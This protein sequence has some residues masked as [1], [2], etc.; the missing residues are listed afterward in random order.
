M[1]QSGL[2]FQNGNW[3]CTFEKLI[4]HHASHNYGQKLYL[5]FILIDGFTLKQYASIQTASFETITRRGKESKYKFNSF[6]EKKKKEIQSEF[7]TIEPNF[8]PCRGGMLL[9]ITGNDIVF[10]SMISP[11]DM[12]VQFGTIS[13][14]AVTLV[15]EDLIIFTSPSSIQ[16][17]EVAIQISFDDGKN[18]IST[19]LKY[20]FLEDNEES[21]K[22][23]VNYYFNDGEQSKPFKRIKREEEEDDEEGIKKE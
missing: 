4:L 23:F 8:G 20:T 1:E 18:F 3:T 13:T 19:G 9:K 11:V 14:K 22:K 21:H 10:S 16:P 6:L 2:R 7:H 17:G 15:T 5:K 12:I